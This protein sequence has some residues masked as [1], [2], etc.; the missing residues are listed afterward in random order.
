M[1]RLLRKYSKGEVYFVTNRTAE[2]LPFVANLLINTFING[3]LARA[4]V[5]H[6]GI[7][8]SA[9]LVMPNHYHLILVL[10]EGAEVLKSFMGYVD[11][12]LAKVINRFRGRCNQ[13][14]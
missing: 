13:N 12:E 14:V 8:L 2:G 1:P 6:P 7:E 9:Y 3:I 4:L 11:G 5:L 10:N